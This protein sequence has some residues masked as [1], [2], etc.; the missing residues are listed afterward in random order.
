VGAPIATPSRIK[1]P[2]SSRCFVCGVENEHGFAL[3]F[4]ET[5]PDTVETTAVIPERYQ[6]DPGVAHGGIVA[7]L[8]DEVTL[9]AAVVGE[10]E[11]RMLTARLDVRFRSSVPVETPL[12]VVG[13]LVERRR[14]ATRTRGEVLLPD[15]RTGAEALLMDHPDSGMSRARL[16]ELGWRVIPD[17]PA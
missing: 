9:R 12:R 1:Q 13:R 7:A 17:G 5:A 10:P 14:R 16:A 2:N 15:G 8:L 6:G 4:Y 3:S 11:H